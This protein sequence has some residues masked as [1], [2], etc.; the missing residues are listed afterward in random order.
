MGSANSCSHGLLACRP[1]PIP[2]L[3]YNI[4]SIPLPLVAFARLLTAADIE[5]PVA[6][7]TS[8]AA[9][10]SA[11]SSCLSEAVSCSK[12]GSASE[13]ST[14]AMALPEDFK[15]PS[16]KALFQELPPRIEVLQVSLI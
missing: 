7:G 16:C 13:L 9:V 1:S 4:S 2:V 8:S 6:G 5:T 12:V 10:S 14:M 15:T 11:A 3:E